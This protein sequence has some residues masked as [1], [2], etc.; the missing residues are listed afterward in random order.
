MRGQDHRKGIL[1]IIGAR[2]SE[3]CLTRAN[4]ISFFII[5]VANQSGQGQ[6]AFKSVNHKNVKDDCGPVDLYEYSPLATPI[7]LVRMPL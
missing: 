4:G 6:F 7:F 1:F 5:S 3:N 2:R